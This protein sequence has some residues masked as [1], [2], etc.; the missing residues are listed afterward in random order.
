M[1]TEE[2]KSLDNLKQS[3]AN[4]PPATVLISQSNL[5]VPVPA[6]ETN[7]FARRLSRLSGLNGDMRRISLGKVQKQSSLSVKDA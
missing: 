5:S 6:A 1:K 3:F 7:S 4:Q 2:D